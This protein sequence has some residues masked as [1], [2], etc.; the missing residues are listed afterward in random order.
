[1][2]DLFE[3][4]VL[5][6][7]KGSFAEAAR[8]LDVVPSTVS[9]K[10]SQLEDHYRVALMQ[11]T[12]R[13]LSLTPEG[14][15]VLDEAREIVGRAHNLEEKLRDTLENPGGTLSITTIPSFGQLHL[16]R[17]LPRFHR[18]YPEIRIHLTLTEKVVDFA[19]DP[20]DV[21]IRM[22][23]LPDS[24]MKARKLGNN[25]YYLCA[26]P[27]YLERSGRPNRPADL[28][29]FSCMTD[30][31]YPALRQWIF[32]TPEGR[33]VV[34]PRGPLQTDDPIARYYATR[35]GMG[36][37]ALPAYVIRGPVDR[38]D[39]EVL[40]P[41]YPL[42]IGEVWALHAPREVVPRRIS[43]FLDFAVLELQ[44]RIRIK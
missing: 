5:V 44:I 3:A 39:L 22:G 1:M 20:H 27:E 2:I 15:L 18:Q 38:G 6:A 35:G 21:A 17:L 31:T 16:A 8:V 11:R 36:I 9:K 10:I 7:E 41:E 25:L 42:D 40:F 24:D 13:Q 29:N 34:N 43:L 37:G 19:T 4:F 14:E 32:D 33:V 23:V 12:T 26:S 30:L 28:E